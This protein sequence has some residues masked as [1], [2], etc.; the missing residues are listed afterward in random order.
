MEN[1]VLL[2]SK[3]AVSL[4]T[5]QNKT[6]KVI[7]DGI[8]PM[9]FTDDYEYARTSRG[10]SYGYSLKSFEKDKSISRKDRFNHF[11]SEVNKNLKHYLT[12][13]CS[14]V[15]AGTDQD[16]ASFKHVSDFNHLIVHEIPGS[17]STS[18]LSQLKQSITQVLTV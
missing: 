1:Y 6:L 8:F 4:L 12:A 11:L 17:Y 14:L 7:N 16:R 2:L 9:D 18:R 3:K 10:N 15:I 13:D 5:F